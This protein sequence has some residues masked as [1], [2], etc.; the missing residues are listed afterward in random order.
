MLK[1]KKKTKYKNRGIL[2]MLLLPFHLMPPRSFTVVIIRND[3][4]LLRSIYV[5][6]PLLILQNSIAPSSFNHH[7][8]PGFKVLV[9]L[10]SPCDQPLTIP[11]ILLLPFL[12]YFFVPIST[13]C[14]FVFKW[15]ETRSHIK[16][17]RCGCI[18]N[19]QNG[20]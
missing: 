15:K 18:M 14:F 8:P 17:S 10:V 2:E 19:L 4:V 13:V 20:I 16:C 3:N 6:R 9:Y 11:L 12:S 7:F 5:L 1:E